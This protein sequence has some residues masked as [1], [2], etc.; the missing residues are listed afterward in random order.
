VDLF[1]EVSERLNWRCH[2]YC[3]MTSHDHVVV[4]TPE[5]NLIQGANRGVTRVCTL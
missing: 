3:Q 5:A 2:A 4:E 1:G